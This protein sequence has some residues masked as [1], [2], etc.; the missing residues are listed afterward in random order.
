MAGRQKAPAGLARLLPEEPGQPPAQSAHC[1]GSHTSCRGTTA[2]HRSLRPD[3]RSARWHS[4]RR[5]PT[6][7][8]RRKRMETN[9]S[10]SPARSDSRSPSPCMCWDRGRTASDMAWTH[11]ASSAVGPGRQRRQKARPERSGRRRSTHVPRGREGDV[12]IPEAARGCCCE[13]W[14]ASWTGL[15]LRG[16]YSLPSSECSLPR[17]HSLR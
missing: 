15:W 16:S 13:G 8:P 7:R 2:R 14:R 1:P 5:R 12:R 3:A 10:A 11:L 4:Q 6:A 17:K 9:W